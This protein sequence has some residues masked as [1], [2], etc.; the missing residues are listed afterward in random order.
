VQS[1]KCGNQNH[2]LNKAGA[3]LLLEAL[4]DQ[5]PDR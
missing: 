1:P 2:P 4:L 3:A 5:A